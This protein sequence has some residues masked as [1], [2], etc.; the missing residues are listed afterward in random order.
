MRYG[1]KVY[2]KMM[3]TD[4]GH[5]RDVFENMIEENITN[6]YR[7]VNRQTNRVEFVKKSSPTLPKMLQKRLVIEL[8]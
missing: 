7:T 1:E 4:D 5:A 3:F 2:S 6:G 8:E